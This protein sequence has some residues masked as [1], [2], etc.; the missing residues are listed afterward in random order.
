MHR[1][2]FLQAGLLTSTMTLG[3][4]YL[5]AQAAAASTAPARDKFIINA[6]IGGNNTVDLLERIGKD[7]L[8]HRPD[9]TILMIG[10]NDMNSRKHVPLP[11]YE[12]NLRKIVSQIREI[13]SAVLL[14]TILPG[15]EPYLYTRHPQA[16]YAPEG[17]VQRNSQVNE[18]IRKVA[19][20]FQQ[21]VL[22]MHYIFEKAGH[23]GEDADSLIQNEANSRKTDGIHPT[24]DGYR[25][26]AVALFEFITQKNL[27]HNQVVCFGDSITH[28]GGG[29]DGKSYP[30]YLKRLLGY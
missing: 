29:V 2:Q 13:N 5:L 11:T 20:D 6:G 16:F 12:E 14:M 17:Y 1:R 27:P 26:M 9:L 22:D 15:Y 8:A 24:P 23:I 28:G 30:A 7:C 3:G 25:T 19:A 18:V 4:K 21:P 10:T